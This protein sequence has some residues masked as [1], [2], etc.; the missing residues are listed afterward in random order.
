MVAVTSD[1]YG[2]KPKHA[3]AG[4]FR[5]HQNHK[6]KYKLALQSAWHTEA[7]KA[8]GRLVR[9]RHHTE[10]ESKLTAPSKN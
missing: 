2:G 6:N 8:Q 7:C 1:L 3:P 5:G 10:E 9:K 4:S